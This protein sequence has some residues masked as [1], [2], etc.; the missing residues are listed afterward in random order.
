MEALHDLVKSGKVRYIGASSMKA[1]EFQKANAIAEK[2]GWTKFV[3]M[4]NLYNL[5]YREEEREMIPYCL[6][7]GIAG[8]PWS[9]LAQGVLTGKN[10]AT[11]REGHG[12]ALM[13]AIS[14]AAHPDDDDKVIDKVVEIAEKRSI[15]P[16]KVKTFFFPFSFT[17]V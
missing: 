5:M 7:E 11:A 2:H 14:K 15:T 16:A 9:P 13:S 6:D 17:K 8:I 12:K 1:T 4:Q 3:S 10:R